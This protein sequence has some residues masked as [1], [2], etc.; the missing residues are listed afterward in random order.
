MLFLALFLN[1]LVYMNVWYG[2][3]FGLVF[4]AAATSVLQFGSHSG[5]AHT[6]RK[7]DVVL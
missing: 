3:N 6:P 1:E 2:S 5:E 7:L 4:V